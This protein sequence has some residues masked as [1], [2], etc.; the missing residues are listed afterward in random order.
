MTEELVSFIQD[1][2][3]FGGHANTLQGSI[4]NTYLQLC[5]MHYALIQ[6]NIYL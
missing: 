6:Q 2:V 5:P 1:F 3:S 4:T